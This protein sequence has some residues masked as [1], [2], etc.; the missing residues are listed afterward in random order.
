[1]TRTLLAL[2]GVAFG[3]VLVLG[4]TLA[5]LASAGEFDSSP[6]VTSAV[7]IIGSPIRPQSAVQYRGVRVGTLDAVEPD[8]ATTSSMLTMTMDTAAM[9]R[10]P[11]NVRVRILPRTLFGDQYVDLAP[12]ERGGPVGIRPGAA[13]PADNRTQTVALYTAYQQLYDTLNGIRPAKI[14]LVLSTIADVL[15]GHGAEIGKTVDTAHRLAVRLG[16]LAK[17]IGPSLDTVA[18][19]TD[20]LAQSA[21]DLFATLD[22]AT[23]LSQFAVRK[24]QD[25]ASLLAGGIDLSGR[26]TAFIE[27]N[28][29]NLITV[30]H[31]ADPVVSVL[32][33]NPQGV[34]DVLRG[35]ANAGRSTDGLSNKTVLDTVLS[36]EDTKTYT[37][38]DCPR[39]GSLA[40]RNCG[41]A[42]PA[43]P[44]NTRS[45]PAAGGTVGSI[46]SPQETRQLHQLLPQLTGTAAPRTAPTPTTDGLLGVLAGPLLRGTTVVTR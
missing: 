29:A 6:T 39:Y 15:R 13:L 38:R 22:N 17:T 35:V 27:D 41:A 5:I 21:P 10:I 34:P 32:A 25:I 33:E 46:G 43:S 14:N 12:R 4:G 20:K 2:R 18:G 26:A 9:A 11:A 36:A 45:A 30:L 40:G 24:Q 42:T 19:I 31:N 8:G 37:P 1:M 16:P 3:M 23:Q 28:Q 7:T 44:A